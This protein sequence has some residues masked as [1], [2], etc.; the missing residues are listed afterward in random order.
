VEGGL[1]VGG[2]DCDEREL[3]QERKMMYKKKTRNDIHSMENMLDR[4]V[5]G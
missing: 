1:R 4:I 2:V 5:S 3:R